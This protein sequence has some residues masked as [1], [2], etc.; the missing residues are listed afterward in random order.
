MIIALFSLLFSYA[1]ASE[2]NLFPKAY[3]DSEKGEMVYGKV[4]QIKDDKITGI[5]NRNQVKTVTE[6]KDIYLLPGLID[7]HTHVLLAQLKGETEFE[8]ALSREARLSP[9]ERIKRAKG[10]LKDYLKAGFTSLCDLGNSGRFLDV[11]LRN[12]TENDKSFPHLYVSG[13]GIATNKGQFP[14]NA[15]MGE[16]NNEYTL[17]DSK[18]DVDKLLQGYLNQKV[19]ILKIYLDNTPGIGGMDETLLKKILANLKSKKFKK[20]T[21]HASEL[22][23]F[24]IAE[25]LPI[26]SLE[27]ANQITLTHT[28]SSLRYVTPTDQDSETL[29]E[30]SYYRQPFYQSQ[31]QRLKQLYQRKFNLVFG[32]DFYFHNPPPFN[33]AHYVKRTLKTYVEANIPRVEILRALTLNPAKSLGE[34]NNIGVIK[35]SAY[36]NLVGFKGNPLEKFD[37][38]FEDPMVINRGS[39]LK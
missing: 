21:Y 4:I 3:F 16:V 1:Q 6:L 5:I 39:F 31:S 2:L 8:D 37:V 27:H 9:A 11:Q 32:P 23:S 25:N 20:I 38:M 26:Q 24:E 34:E 22:K 36:A 33:R 10:F 30:F 12:Q 19:D 14:A 17:V 18:T 35:K 13:P 15:K 29:K 7:C 28:M